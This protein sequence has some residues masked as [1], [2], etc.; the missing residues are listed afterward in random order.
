[1]FNVERIVIKDFAGLGLHD[2]KEFDFAILKK[3]M[4][5][6]G[7]NGCGKSSFLDIYF[8]LAPAKTDFRVGGSYVNYCEKDEAKYR[9]SIKRTEANLVCS[10]KNITTGEHICK[11]VNPKVYNMH[12]EDIFGLTKEI[13][14]ILNGRARLTTANSTLRKAW[15]S[16]LSTTDMTYGLKF[17]K[18]LR[19][20]HR[21]LGAVS[22]HLARKIAEIKLK[23]VESKEERDAVKARLDEMEQQLQA[24]SAA[25]IKELEA[26]RGRVSSPLSVF[27]HG[28]ALKAAEGVQAIPR[29][30]DYSE[31]GI[32][33]GSAVLDGHSANV[34][35]C[36]GEIKQ[37]NQQLA[38][39][40]NALQRQS[41]LMRNHS[42]LQEE[43]ERASASLVTL[44]V[45]VA[46]LK[47]E[48]LVELSAAQLEQTLREFPTV[49]KNLS[50]LLESITGKRRI[51]SAEETVDSMQNRRAQLTVTIEH[52]KVRI[53]EI[54]HDI[55][56]FDQTEDVNCP[57]CQHSF[58]PGVIRS[59]EELF[60][61]HAMN[62]GK[63]DKCVDELGKLNEDIEPLIH[64]LEAMRGL[65]NLMLSHS[66]HPALG[67]F[68]KVL[69]SDEILT[70]N[71]AKLNMYINQFEAEVQTVI[72]YH[73][74]TA[75]HVKLTGEW[76]DAVRSVGELD[77]KLLAKVDETRG[78]LAQA[79]ERLSHA[80]E[81]QQACWEEITFA[82]RCQCNVEEFDRIQD[83]LRQSVEATFVEGLW[84]VLMRNKERLLDTYSAC[85]T[86]WSAMESELKQLGELEREHAEIVEKRHHVSQMIQAW[87]PE[88]GVLQRYYFRAISRITMLMTAHIRKCWTYDIKV[89][90]CSADG[91]DLNYLFPY[92]LKNKPEPVS[93][94]AKSSTG[95]AEIIN[96][97]F[98]LVAYQA[99]GLTQYPLLLDEP[100]TG[101]DE[102]HRGKLV[103]FIKQLVDTGMFS[104]LL[105]VSHLSDVH[106]K[107]NEAEYCVIEPE[108]VTLPERYNEAIRIVY[109]VAE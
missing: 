35:R 81:W 10:I 37:L 100:A 61:A 54:E 21:D 106:S 84:D 70:V 7:G 77:P 13:V 69:Y 101:F 41:Y 105:V 93:D 87:S 50:K 103:N 89:L 64:E 47:Y 38:E 33:T 90:P 59:K 20:M 104:Q 46:E 23:T 65:R 49:V 39:Y 82:K 26:Y 83:Q 73:R 107:L 42:S 14:E 75:S 19:T 29:G 43:L 27:H 52:C 66:N 86:R 12:I 88:K 92:Q 94:I 3:M 71:R 8:P 51:K 15:F 109:D 9:C 76:E 45:S 63:L 62:S 16:L 74:C 18:D 68:F 95:Q 91:G 99:L 28:S 57:N 11:E 24:Y 80:K 17:Y 22:D 72:E 4:I 5:I 96:L 55:S 53:A 34:S 56:H 78:K 6:L 79:S 25:S 32:A 36:E 97:A 102:N 60:S 85:R 40:E 1:M 30:L 108:G 44:K 98:R 48:M 31:Q 58:K 2:I 67:G